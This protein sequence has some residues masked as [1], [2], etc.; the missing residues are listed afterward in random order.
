M[1]TKRIAQLCC[2]ALVAAGI[3]LNIQNAIANYGI[4]ENSCS[5]VAIGGSGGFGP[6]GE[7]TGGSGSSGSCVEVSYPT[8]CTYSG[9]D[10]EET[11][12]IFQRCGQYAGKWS[13]RV[14]II[15]ELS[16]KLGALGTLVTFG[17]LAYRIWDSQQSHYLMQLHKRITDKTTTVILSDGD[18]PVTVPYYELYYSCDELQ[19]HGSSNCENPG[20][21]QFISYTLD[22]TPIG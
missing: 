17:D 10:I 14:G 5:L 15:K 9:I 3:G 22:C 16:K 21:E 7:Q 19:G 1:K 20:W 18:I 6:G 8:T 11:T 2:A 4:G 12:M 13:A